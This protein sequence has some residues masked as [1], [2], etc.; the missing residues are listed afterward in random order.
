MVRRSDEKWLHFWVKEKHQKLF[1]KRR[2]HLPRLNCCDVVRSPFLCNKASLSKALW[3]WRLILIV[4][5]NRALPSFRFPMTAC[6][7]RKSLQSF[8][9]RP[10]ASMLW[11]KVLKTWTEANV[12]FKTAQPFNFD[13]KV[14]NVTNGLLLFIRLTEK[15]QDFMRNKGAQE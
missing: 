7:F 13:L 9:L 10:N 1:L 11:V 14:M 8:L 15:V 2:L 12:S 6:F 4:I 5:F 3:V